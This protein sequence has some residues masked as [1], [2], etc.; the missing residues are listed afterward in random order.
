MVK[1][2][3]VVLE[4]IVTNVAVSE[5]PL[6]NNWIESETARIGDTYENGE[7]VSPKA[8][9]SV[10]QQVTALQG[11]LAIDQAGLAAVFE[12]WANDPSRTFAERAF[13]NKALV[14]KRND[15]VLV[16]GAQELGIT[17][18]LDQLFTMAAQL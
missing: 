5:S 8:P 6:D 10:P 1:Q 4:G 3:A 13:I 12:A 2:F 15:P 16:A 14:W 17:H 7:F 9:S 11:M 18:Q